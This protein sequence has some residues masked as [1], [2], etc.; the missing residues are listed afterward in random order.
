MDKT[1]VYEKVLEMNWYETTYFIQQNTEN[2]IK[3]FQ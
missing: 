3:K 1:K 2:R